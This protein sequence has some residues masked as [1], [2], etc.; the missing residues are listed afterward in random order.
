MLGTV[1][2]IGTICN[3]MSPKV[4]FSGRTG[5]DARALRKLPTMRNTAE[6]LERAD[7]TLVHAFM[8]LSHLLDCRFH[9]NQFSLAHHVMGAA[10][11]LFGAQSLQDVL[12][13]WKGHAPV[14]VSVS[15]AF[16]LCAAFFSIDLVRLRRAADAYERQPQRI[17][18]HAAHYLLMPFF[19][20]LMLLVLGTLI[21]GILTWVDLTT[22]RAPPSYFIENFWLM[23]VG[24]SWYIA[25]GTPPIR[26]R[27]K[28]TRAP[29]IV[30][31][32]GA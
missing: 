26:G 27:K 15:L 8:R 28:K 32:Q 7:R 10:M 22:R 5:L 19:L 20:R 9:L 21:A 18:R 30:T 31:L 23:L 1:D 25:G 16:L 11:A 24:S 6:L 14:V 4:C 13:N 29:A 17:S 3:G 2:P 12:R